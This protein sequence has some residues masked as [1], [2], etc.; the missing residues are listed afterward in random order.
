MP[1]VRYTV[2]QPDGSY[3]TAA[4]PNARQPIRTLES[5]PMSD[6][7]KARVREWRERHPQDSP[8]ML[9]SASGEES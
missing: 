8:R 4:H 5:V 2:Q 1:V 6:A 9:G 7:A 3:V